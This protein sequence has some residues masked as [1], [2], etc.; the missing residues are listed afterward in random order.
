MQSIAEA[1]AG[2]MKPKRPVVIAKQPYPEALEVLQWHANQLNC[3]IIRPQDLIELTAKQTLQENGTMVQTIAAQPHALPWMQPTGSH[4]PTQ[5]HAK[6]LNY[7]VNSLHDLIELTA[8]C[9]ALNATYN[10][11][12]F[13]ALSDFSL[14]CLPSLPNSLSLHHVV[15]TWRCHCSQNAVIELQVLTACQATLELGSLTICVPQDGHA[16]G[17]V[18]VYK[19]HE[20]SFSP[21]IC[22]VKHLS[23]PLQWPCSKAML[24]LQT[25]ML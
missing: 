21:P 9:P 19:R 24:F 23:Q 17:C 20:Y 14:L 25:D 8:A 3:P 13:A 4:N 11:N 10:C 16:R 6:Q 18:C 2:I 15:H 22:G 1:K 12:S 5:L 7:T